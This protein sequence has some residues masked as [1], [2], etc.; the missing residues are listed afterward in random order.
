MTF[1]SYVA[2]F[3]I[4]TVLILYFLLRH[5]RPQNILLL[6]ASL[7]FYSF[8]EP[9]F[10]LLLI[11]CIVVS[12]GGARAVA[13]RPAVAKPIL[14]V[15]IAALLGILG[16]FKYFNFFV[17]S[18]H[19]F[20]VAIGLPFQKVTLS[21]GLPIAISFYTFQSIGYLVDVYRDPEHVEH[22]FIDYALF[23]SF[24]PQLV[25]GP[26]ERSTN[27]LQQLKSD[28]TVTGP[29]V[30][31]GTYLIIQGYVKKV[32]IADNLAP[33]VDG[34]LQNPSLGGPI[35]AVAMLAFAFQIYCDFSGYTDIARGISR[36]MGI[37]ILLNFRHPYISRNFTEFWRRWHITLSNWFRDYVY[38]PLGGSRCSE[39]RTLLN[40]LITMTVSGLWHGASANFAL[41]GFYHGILLIIHKLYQDHVRRF[42]PSRAT[43]SSTYSAVCWLVTFSLTLYGWLLFRVEDFDL[44]QGYTGQLLSS[45][46]LGDIAILL[47]SQIGPFVLLAAFMDV[48][49]TRYLD[50]TNSEVRRTKLLPLYLALL[51]AIIVLFGVEGGGDFIYFRF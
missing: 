37:R 2:V 16:I 49:E 18:F 25:A 48:M 13:S 1:N 36:I 17:D 27:L 43:A 51:A 15:C 11:T 33:I 45:W 26:I 42:L 9:L 39:P 28:R 7:I 34:V 50:I 38:I 31:Y 35:I 24:F 41:W 46:R 47:F 6:V 5:R 10:I 14:V 19:V 30:T 29:D 23:I 12:F 22:N 8:G 44:I 40:L 4:A 32:V 20:F 3:F 21:I